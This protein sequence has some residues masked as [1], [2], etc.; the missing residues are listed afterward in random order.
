[1]NKTLRICFRL[2]G[3]KVTVDIVSGC[4]RK[5]V[6]SES[7]Q[8]TALSNVWAGEYKE[9]EDTSTGNTDLCTEHVADSLEHTFHVAFLEPSIA[10]FL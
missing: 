3:S 9:W 6:Q 7:Y 2:A 10:D 1:M 5:V 8:Q 4:G